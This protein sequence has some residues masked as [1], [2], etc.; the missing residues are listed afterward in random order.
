MEKRRR[1]ERRQRWLER[2][3][4]LFWGA[5]HLNLV[6]VLKKGKGVRY[7]NKDVLNYCGIPRIGPQC[8]STHPAR[9]SCHSTSWKGLLTRADSSSFLLCL[10]L[11]PFIFISVANTLVVILITSNW[12]VALFSNRSLSSHYLLQFN[13]PEA[14]KCIFM[15]HHFIFI[16]LLIHVFSALPTMPH[17]LPW[18]SRFPERLLTH[19]INHSS[20]ARTLLFPA[21][22]VSS[23][24]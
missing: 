17:F 6:C 4:T 16:S 20:S 3:R 5:S 1:I 7:C 11:C 13:L 2:Y 15:K 9:I 10:P 21:S 23:L 18:R 24:S 14:T 8:H 12:T 22:L 19:V